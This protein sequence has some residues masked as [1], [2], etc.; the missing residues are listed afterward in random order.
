MP[1]WEP[2]P[3]PAELAHVWGWFCELDAGR[4]FR[5]NGQP[6]SISYQDI[7][8]WAQLTGRSPDPFEVKVLRRLDHVYFD[9]VRNPLAMPQYLVEQMD[10]GAQL[11]HAFRMLKALQDE[12][13]ANPN[14]TKF[15]S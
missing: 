12:G 13:K 1:D 6:H 5:D 10:Q 4:H 3:P 8:A 7:A 11:K 9:C 14:Q 15:L 2:P